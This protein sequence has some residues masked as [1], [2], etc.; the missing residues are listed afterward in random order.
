VLP[1][2]ELLLT[3]LQ[4]AELNHKDAHDTAMLLLGHELSES[5]GPGR[6]NMAQVADI[7]G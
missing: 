2:A 3:K 6:L 7:V 1:A 4:I 5:D